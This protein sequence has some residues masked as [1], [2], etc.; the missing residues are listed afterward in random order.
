MTVNVLLPIMNQFGQMT[1]VRQS[2]YIQNRNLLRLSMNMKRAKK[3]LQFPLIAILA[4]IISCCINML[5]D[6]QSSVSGRQ[7]GPI[8]LID[9]TCI[10]TWIWIKVEWLFTFYW[11]V[12]VSLWNRSALLLKMANRLSVYAFHV[13]QHYV[14][15]TNILLLNALRSSCF[16]YDC[17]VVRCF[18]DI[19][20]IVRRGLRYIMNASYMSLYD[21]SLRILTAFNVN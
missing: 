10:S 21:E 4:V 1:P 17:T 3:T 14:T 11:S 15:Q 20:L 7:M 12:V 5:S 6:D 16:T 13:N 19:K 18:I 8:I 9:I 2:Y